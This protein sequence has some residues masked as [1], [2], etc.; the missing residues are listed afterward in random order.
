[1]PGVAQP[2]KPGRDQAQAMG[3]FLPE[4]MNSINLRIS[5][6][7]PPTCSCDLK[8]ASTTVIVPSIGDWTVE[9]STAWT[10]KSSNIMRYHIIGWVSLI[11]NVALKNLPCNSLLLCVH[12]IWKVFGVL[13][14]RKI[15]A[16]VMRF[17][18]E[19]TMSLDTL[20]PKSFN[21]K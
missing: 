16:S 19:M 9:R 15:I 6:Q 3:F 10:V 7:L 1:M 14:A 4:D 12:V 17:F 8:S 2:G 18:T 13:A 5:R 11:T 21:S 20:R